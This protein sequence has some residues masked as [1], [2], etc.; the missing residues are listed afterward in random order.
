MGSLAALK[1][2]SNVTLDAKYPL[3]SYI[4]SASKLKDFAESAD[5]AGNLEESYVGYR[6]MG[7]CVDV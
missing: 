7:K 6:K 3:R 5:R 2:K 4:S 1:L